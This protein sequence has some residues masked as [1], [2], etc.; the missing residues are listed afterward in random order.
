MIKKYR[1]LKVGQKDPRIQMTTPGGGKNHCPSGPSLQP[2]NYRWQIADSLAMWTTVLTLL[3][4]PLHSAE[5]I[6]IPHRHS[7]GFNTDPSEAD[8]V[9]SFPHTAL[10]SGY[11][12]N[13]ISLLG[14]HLCLALLAA[15][16][17]LPLL[18]CHFN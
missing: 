10:V 15:S 1:F 9:F 5:L 8:F 17:P 12:A 18:L 3:L 6:I 16:Q 11:F 2:P 13:F 7:Q 4:R 14:R